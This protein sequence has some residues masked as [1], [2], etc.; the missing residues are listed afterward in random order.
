M[1]IFSLSL[2]QQPSTLQQQ[3][4]NSGNFILTNLLLCWVLFARFMFASLSPSLESRVESRGWWIL[5][6]NSQGTKSPSLVFVEI[7]LCVRKQQ[8]KRRNY[9]HRI[10]KVSISLCAELSSFLGKN[11]FQFKCS[12]NTE[13]FDSYTGGILYALLGTKVF[14]DEVTLNLNILTIYSEF[15]LS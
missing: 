11:C 10:E 13:E 3:R 7:S 8:P 1:Q 5:F 4:K 15:S 14:I 12:T 6:S 9:L 2:A